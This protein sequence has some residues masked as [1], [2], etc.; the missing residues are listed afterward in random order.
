MEQPLMTTMLQ[1]P[2]Q[3]PRTQLPFQQENVDE[4]MTIK[5]RWVDR[6]VESLMQVSIQ[7]GGKWPG[8]KIHT[9]HPWGRTHKCMPSRPEAAFHDNAETYLTLQAPIS[10]DSQT[11]RQPYLTLSLPSSTRDCHLSTSLHFD[12]H[13]KYLNSFLMRQYFT[14]PRRPCAAKRT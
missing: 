5:T 4:K 14:T 10:G 11:P 6:V 13:Y 7:R 3:T 2:I 12:L 1:H 9:A 8:D